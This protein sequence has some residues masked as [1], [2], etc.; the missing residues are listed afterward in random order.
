[1]FLYL[2]FFGL[3]FFIIKQK[4]SLVNTMSSSQLAT[5]TI[6]YFNLIWLCSIFN[7]DKFFFFNL[8]IFLPLLNLLFLFFFKSIPKKIDNFIYFLFFV[9]FSLAIVISH[10]LYFS[11]DVRLYWFEKVL[12]FYNDFFVTDDKTFKAEYPHF[13]T[14]LWSFFWTNSF[15]NYEYFGRLSYLFIYV[16]SISFVCEIFHKNFYIKAILALII[17]FLSF[18]IKHFDGRQDILLFSIN[19]IIFCLFYK[20]F[21]ENKDSDLNFLLLLLSINLLLWT[22]TEGILYLIIYNFIIFI[23]SKSRKKYYFLATSALILSVKV[24]FY[25]HYNLS[26][27]PSTGMFDKNTFMLLF[28]IPIIERSL[29]IFYWYFI[30]ILKNPLLLITSITFIFLCFRSKYFFLKYKYVM[31]I[32]IFLFLGIFFT[33]LPTKYDFPFA[34]VGGL[35]RVLYQHGALFLL[36]ILANLKKLT[37]FKKIYV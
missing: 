2:S 23:F 9:F 26:F 4:G 24:Y 28:N 17:I 18:E 36:P 13:G 12:L 5:N 6:I 8:L 21:I 30:S 37:I 34:M 25:F 7:F 10:D 22:K 33:Y 27:N 16:A 3:P 32:F 35:D 29:L 20:I 14:Y 31:C 1:M 19:A 11:H 15:I